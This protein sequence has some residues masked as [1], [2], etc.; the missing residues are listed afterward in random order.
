MVRL[1][2]ILFLLLTISCAV[3]HAS[4]AGQA[5]MLSLDQALE[6]AYQNNLGVQNAGLEVQKAADAIDAATTRFFPSLHFNGL[7][8]Y[9]LTRQSYEFSRGTWGTYKEIGPVPPE[10][11]EV[12][13]QIGFTTALSATLSQPLSQLYRI[14]LSVEQRRIK[15]E[16]AAEELRAKQQSVAKEVKD[17]YYQVLQKQSALAAIEESI[18]F[19][20]ELDALTER[21]LQ[22]QTVLKSE[23]LEVKTRLAKAELQALTHKNDLADVKEQL[24]NLMGRDITTPF[25]VIQVPPRTDYEV[26]LEAAQALALAQ[27]PE[28]KESQLK[29]RYAE[30]NRRIKKSEYIPDLWFKANYDKL[31]NVE[32]LPNDVATIGLLLR[33]EF[34][35]WGRKQSELAARSRDIQTAK[36]NVKETQDHVILQVN[37]IGRKLNEARARLKVAALSRATA[38]E[39]LRIALQQFGQK[40]VLL[41]NLLQ[42]ET[43]VMEANRQ[44]E[45]ALLG[46]WKTK[47]AFENALGEA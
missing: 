2:A 40:T 45:D 20:R 34:Y 24:N 5:A 31:Y 17:A 10:N 46:F 15:K 33:W 13:T 30:H 16:M 42:A 27:R 6:L 11:V 26:D 28:I 29:L 32:L 12:D 39:K 35:D 4:H 18:I 23:Q 47:A 21:Y 1:A 25:N 3:S 8:S 7:E 38:R 14:D 19:Y 36:N 22:E 37:K 44:Y 41:E 43:D 9:N